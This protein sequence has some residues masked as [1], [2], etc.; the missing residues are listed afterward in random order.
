[1]CIPGNKPVDVPINTPKSKAIINSMS[2]EIGYSIK[3][4]RI[5]L[6]ENKH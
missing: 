4:L 6:I 2:I 3:F 5:I 1:M